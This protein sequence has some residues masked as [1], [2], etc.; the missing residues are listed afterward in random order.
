GGDDGGGVYIKG[1]NFY[2]SVS[3]TDV[4]ISGNSASGDG[5]GIDLY[6]DGN[7]GHYASLKLDN[8]QLTGNHAGGDGGGLN[9]QVH[10]YLEGDVSVTAS[11]VSGNSAESNGG[12]MNIDVGHSYTKWFYANYTWY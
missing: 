6:A 4:A 10:D 3:F 8:V 7:F 9:L 2:G 1:H 5:G 11:D 12:G